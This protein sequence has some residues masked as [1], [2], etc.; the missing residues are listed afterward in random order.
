MVYEFV[1]P[2]IGKAQVIEKRLAD[3]DLKYKVNEF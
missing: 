1:Y 3:L 2:S